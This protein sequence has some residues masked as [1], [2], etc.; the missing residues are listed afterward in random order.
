M[1]AAKAQTVVA[2]VRKPGNWAG[3]VAAAFATM[4][5]PMMEANQF[6]P[7]FANRSDGWHRSRKNPRRHDPR[8]AW[9]GYVAGGS[10]VVIV[11]VPPLRDAEDSVDQPLGLG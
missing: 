11:I 8:R 9:G 10:A 1:S 4:P 6:G 5:V 2:A 7:R 3:R